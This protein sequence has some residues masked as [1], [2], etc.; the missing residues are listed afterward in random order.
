MKKSGIFVLILLLAIIAEIW[1]L[2][3]C[4]HTPV[5][6]EY[7][8]NVAEYELPKVDIP[9]IRPFA[10]EYNWSEEIN[11][12]IDKIK[13]VLKPSNFLVPETGENKSEAKDLENEVAEADSFLRPADEDNALIAVV[14]DDVGLSV[15][16]TN[17]IAQIKKP[18]TVAFLPYGAS[19]KKQVMQLKNAGFEVMLHV[20]MMPHVPASL[21]PNTLSP[22][23]GQKKIQNGF[24]TML[25]RFAGTGMV[26]VNNHMGSRFTEDK[27]AMSA[28][29][30]LL[31]QKNMF[32]LDSKTSA[33]SVAKHVCQKYNVPYIARDV[34]LD[35]EKKYEAIMAQFLKAEQI[36]KKH[37]YAVAIGHPY[38]QTLEVLKDWEAQN[39]KH[40]VKIVPLSYLVKKANKNS[41]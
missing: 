5:V 36:A 19:N 38:K 34:F 40:N 16:F 6:S 28:V 7:E 1:E 10:F 27:D 29:I 15:P 30:E 26:G 20:P 18:I 4:I 23:M 33:K 25:N 41:L 22:E 13:S 9:T 12:E 11:A 17:Q 21:A 2:F 14:I 39:E 35:N 8:I 32:F 31:A 24:E 3:K 37:G